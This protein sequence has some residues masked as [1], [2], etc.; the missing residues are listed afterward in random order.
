MKEMLAGCAIG[1]CSDSGD[2]TIWLVIL[3][4]ALGL[5][6]IMLIYFLVKKIKKKK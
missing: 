5:L 6:L 2:G 3:F 4:I 1:G